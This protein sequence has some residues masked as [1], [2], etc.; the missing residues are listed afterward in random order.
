MDAQLLIQLDGV[1]IE[2]LVAGETTLVG[3][4]TVSLALLTT[5]TTPPALDAAA[6]AIPGSR[7][8]PPPVPSRPVS[9]IP[10]PLPPRVE[11]KV[12]PSQSNVNALVP[13]PLPSRPSSPVP[14][15]APVYADTIDQWLILQ[16]ASATGTPIFEMPIPASTRILSSP[17]A[18]YV[19]PSAITNWSALF[20]GG[21]EKADEGD[22]SG[23]IKMT[24]PPTVSVESREAL[25]HYLWGLASF[26]SS[27]PDLRSRLVLV[28][29]DRGTII[30]ELSTD[31]K[32]DED[33][34]LALEGQGAS[35]EKEPVV[36]DV[37][38]SSKTGLITVRPVSAW[39]ATE[40]PTGSSIISLADFV[41]RGIV[42]GAEVVGRGLSYGAG[43]FVEGTKPNESPLVFSD[44]TKS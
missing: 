25:E 28:D 20:G 44:R 9:P 39:K 31:C 12:A 36:V 38:S 24:L 22:G 41:S 27:T 5:T 35:H 14:A 34:H 30:G 3:V 16:L 6:P 18:S 8:T 2:H 17:P 11:T 21:D 37:G 23:F 13:P 1:T 29:E 19:I 33:P 43:K 15:A 42:V 10:P 26:A 7:T 40:N 4:G 32:I